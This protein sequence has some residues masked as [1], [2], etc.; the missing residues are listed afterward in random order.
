MGACIEKTI[1]L[2]VEDDPNDVLIVEREFKRRGVVGLRVVHDGIEAVRY[3][4]GKGDYQDRIKF[5]MPDVVLLDL[6]MPRFSGFDFLEWLRGRAPG[7]LHLIPI[8]VLSS[9]DEPGDVRRA[10]ALGVNSYIV[11]PLHW[12]EF[13]DKM[14]ALSVYWSQH[15]ETPVVT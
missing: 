12:A 5:P 15:V 3:L 6:K 9:S 8:V 13:Q 14:R 11:K 4:E 1:F 2:L 10:Y 7:H